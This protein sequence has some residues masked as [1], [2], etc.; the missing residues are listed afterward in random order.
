[1]TGFAN[2]HGW[3]WTSQN[4]GCGGAEKGRPCKEATVLVGIGVGGAQSTQRRGNSTWKVSLN[5]NVSFW[6][7]PE[8]NVS[9]LDRKK[10][11]SQS[12]RD[13]LDLGIG[14]SPNDRSFR[15]ATLGCH[16]R[17]SQLGGTSGSE[18]LQVLL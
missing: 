1:M 11:K 15:M 5:Q 6:P 17:Q 2:I 13:T 3:M 14:W 12:K 18:N 7:L 10:G 4:T 16:I 8:P 9:C